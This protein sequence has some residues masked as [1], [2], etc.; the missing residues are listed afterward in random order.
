MR[1]FL[2]ILDRRLETL[3]TLAYGP[4]PMDEYRVGLVAKLAV[5]LVFAALVLIGVA[6]RW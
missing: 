2:I 6:A 5:L 3:A 1:R 4:L